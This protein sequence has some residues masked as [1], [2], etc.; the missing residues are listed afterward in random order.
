MFKGARIA[1]GR[2]YE[3]KGE[4]LGRLFGELAKSNQNL[5]EIK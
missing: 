5:L 2:K 4:F 1:S 3:V